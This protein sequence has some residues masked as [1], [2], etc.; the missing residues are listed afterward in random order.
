M[1][2]SRR[3]TDREVALILRKASE[4][5][6]KQGG[7]EGGGLSLT[8]LREI[9][10]EVGISREAMDRA[11]RELNRKGTPSVIGGAPLVRRAV[12]VVDGRGSAPNFGR[13]FAR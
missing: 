6:E 8:D 3:F 13:L 12:H 11:V 2:D 5:E 4:I 1:D 9:A 10:G 7:A